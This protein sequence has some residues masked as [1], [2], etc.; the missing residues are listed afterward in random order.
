[1]NIETLSLYLCLLQ[2]LLSMAYSF[3]CNVFHLFGQILEIG[4]V[5]KGTLKHTISRQQQQPVVSFLKMYT[6]I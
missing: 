3:Q 5:L 1:M 2:F 4:I 6:I